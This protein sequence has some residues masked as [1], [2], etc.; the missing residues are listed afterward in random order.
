MEPSSLPQGLG[1]HVGDRLR[2]TGSERSVKNK[3]VTCS[4]RVHCCQL[5]RISTWG[6]NMSNRFVYVVGATLIRNRRG[7]R[8]PLVFEVDQ[9]CDLTLR[10]E[11]LRTVDQ[12]A[13][14]EKLG[15]RKVTNISTFLKVP[16]KYMLDGLT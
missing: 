2:L 14:H 11:I 7:D 10:L 16:S 9:T 12:V 15:E 4:R 6:Q 13:P 1:N 8:Q 3:R 5:R